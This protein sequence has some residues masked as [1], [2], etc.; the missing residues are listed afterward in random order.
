M[1]ILSLS[2]D[3]QMA[4]V[5]FTILIIIILLL[6]LSA[7]TKWYTGWSPLSLLLPLIEPIYSLF[8]P[9]LDILPPF[10]GLTTYRTCSLAIGHCKSEGSQI[11][12][13]GYKNAVTLKV[14]MNILT[15]FSSGKCLERA[16]NKAWSVH[17]N[18]K[19]VKYMGFKA[20]WSEKTKKMTLT[21]SLEVK[22][23]ATECC[24]A[25]GSSSVGWK[26][27]TIQCKCD[28]PGSHDD[29]NGKQDLLTLLNMK[30]S[31]PE[32]KNRTSSGLH[33]TSSSPL[34][35]PLGGILI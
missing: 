21:L 9:V 17:D 12:P 31:L 3:K 10:P 19:K 8:Q 2:Y 7:L 13:S 14:P 22:D 11:I 1:I 26:C 34:S 23:G 4:S 18:G 6:S 5:F 20:S 29:D 32:N 35:F 30:P 15:G 25:I 33:V 16:I 27:S 28:M 24:M